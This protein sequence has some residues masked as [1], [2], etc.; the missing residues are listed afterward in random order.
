MNSALEEAMKFHQ[1]MTKYYKSTPEKEIY[2]GIHIKDEAK[3]L[4]TGSFKIL[5]VSYAI[6]K[7]FEEECNGNG[8]QGLCD[9]FEQRK[10]CFVTASD[11]NFGIAVSYF[12]K[13]IYQKC[14]VYLPHSTPQYYIDKIA[15]NN[16]TIVFC[17][18]DYDECV[19]SAI[20][21]S[22]GNNVK[23]VL[24]TA[25][26]GKFMEEVARNVIVGYCTMF[27]ESRNYYDY[28][29]IP[30]GV[31]G[32]LAAA[33]LYN[34]H[35][36]NKE[37]KIISVEPETYNCVQQS[38]CR[39]KLI[40]INGSDTLMN[41]LKCGTPSE[42]AWPFILNGTYGCLCI[43]DYECMLGKKELEI[44]GIETGATGSTGYSGYKVFEKNK[45]ENLEGK[46]ILI[47]NT[48]KTDY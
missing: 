28:M 2:A 7:M 45:I 24:D 41:G 44:Y 4:N 1:G 30:T 46:K 40:R 37:C 42:Y 12:C 23:L 33:I 21:F 16:A 8:F 13:L 5:G 29:F 32:L 19:N 34:I 14:K 6:Y 47:I 18:G 39:G 20:Q 35:I 22:I 36:G 31:G 17:E 9:Y 11:G 25:I 10:V 38:I 15:E 26:R 48:E 3:R 43:S 27:L